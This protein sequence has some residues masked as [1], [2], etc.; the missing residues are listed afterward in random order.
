[1]REVELIG[2]TTSTPERALTGRSVGVVDNRAE[3]RAFLT[4]RRAKI[5]PEQ[6][7]LPVGGGLRRVPGL[8]REEVAV[9]AGVSTDWY[10]RLEKGHIDGVSEE[11][12][13]AVARALQLAEAERLHLFDLARAAKPARAQRRR[14]AHAAVRPSVLRILESMAATPA[15]VRNGRLDVLAIN[16]LGQALYS[17][18]FEDPNRPVNLARFCFLDSRSR[19]FYP[20]WDEVAQS[21]VA[22][23]R[24][25][26]GRDPYNHELTDMIGELATRSEQFRTAWAAHNVTLHLYGA[27]HFQH[28]VVGRIDVTFDSMDLPADPGLTLTAYSTEPGSPSEDTLTLLA[29]WSVTTDTTEPTDSN[30]NA[31]P[32]R[33]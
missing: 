5:T 17:P 33:S 2:G 6:A 4:T 16:P 12:L 24:T 3:I 26:A 9:L 30:E 28:P 32:P 19:G 18:A 8:R 14:T 15:F 10:V 22:V 20:D 31:R 29:S 13:D 1:M 7:G 23:L 11:V 21:T 27:K 25:E